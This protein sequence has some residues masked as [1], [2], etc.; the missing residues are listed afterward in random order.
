LISV[1]S[2]IKNDAKVNSSDSGLLLMKKLEKRFGIIQ[3]LF[4]CLST[5]GSKIE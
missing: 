3:L 2:V 5:H 4:K 1:K